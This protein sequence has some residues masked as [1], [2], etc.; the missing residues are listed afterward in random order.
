MKCLEKDRNRRYETVNDLTLD[1]ERYLADEP[2][3]A[4]PPSA[5]YRFCKFT[6][7]NKAGLTMA[8]LILSILVLLGGVAGWVVRDR[9]AR[10]AVNEREVVR[11]LDEATAFQARSKWPE[12][13][14]AAKRAEG[15]LAGGASESLRQRVRELRKDLE[16]VLR[17][18]EIWLPRARDDSRWVD[19][20]YAEAF[21]AYG[22]DVEALEPAEA[23]AR[24]RARSIWLELAVALDCW[25]DRRQSVQAIDPVWDGWPDQRDFNPEANDASWKRLMAV[26]RAA[27]P[28]EFRDQ[29]RAALEQ[30]DRKMLSK[31]TASPDF[32]DL[33]AQMLSVVCRHVDNEPVAAAL[34]RAQLEHP[35][36]FA[37]NGQLAWLSR[38][39]DEAIRFFTVALALRPRHAGTAWILGHR[40]SRRGKLD[41][42]IALYRKAIALDPDLVDSYCGLIEALQAQGKRDEALAEIR[43]ALAAKPNS[44]ALHNSVAWTLA[45]CPDARFRDPRLAVELASR[46]VA[47]APD[48]GYY[49]QTLGAAHY[50]AGDWNGAIGA[51]EKSMPLRKRGSSS[52]WFFLAMACWQRGRRDEARMWYDRAVQWM[53]KHDPKHGELC[54]F[55]AEAATLLGLPKPAA[56]AGKEVAHPAKR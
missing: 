30:R 8:G 49:W 46:A 6:R 2:V 54:L 5:W 10:L 45:T 22:I 27:D 55:R 41:E 21:R 39:R 44:A 42:A 56:P 3:R 11:A 24:I 4:C 26:A 47:L 38:D 33:P 13:L 19:A 36:N 7:R 25:A 37:V 40:L 31:L 17:L 20:S 14:E 18:E 32:S 12:A 15:F 53:E 34:K 35:D 43:A 1:V 16:M 50:R 23:A 28:D 51:L 52:D 48:Q 9:A 29:V